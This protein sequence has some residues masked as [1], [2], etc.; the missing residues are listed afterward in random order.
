MHG[1]TDART[2]APRFE[3]LL[4]VAASGDARRV[5]EIVAPYGA[6]FQLDRQGR[7]PL[8]VAAQNGHLEVV[9]A[10]LDAFGDSVQCANVDRAHEAATQRG[11]EAISRRLLDVCSYQQ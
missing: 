1:A 8:V 2:V 6:R 11:D 9:N 4:A 3:E 5:G 10:L 7:S